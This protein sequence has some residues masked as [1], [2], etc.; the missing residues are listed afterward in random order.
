MNI[1]IRDGVKIIRHT[2][3]VVDVY[4]IEQTEK[5]R[6]I[7]IKE[8]QDVQA[9]L[10]SVTTDI[11]AMLASQKPKLVKRIINRLLRKTEV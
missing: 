11:T 7:L 4:G 1:E 5:F 3:G 6:D 2:T 8:K 10:D 9:N